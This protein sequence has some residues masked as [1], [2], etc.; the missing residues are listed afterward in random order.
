MAMRSAI[1]CCSLMIILTILPYTEAV[2]SEE[3]DNDNME[4]GELL[5][6][7][8]VIGHML[9]TNPVTGTFA[10]LVGVVWVV[11]LHCCCAPHERRR[12]TPSRRTRYAGIGAYAASQL[13][14]NT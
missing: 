9:Y 10:I 8:A 7:L 6:H 5:V 11:T 3:E 13:C 14:S 1:V 12:F 2:D 4:L